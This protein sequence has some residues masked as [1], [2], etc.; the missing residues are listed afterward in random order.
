MIQIQIQKNW[1][2][3]FA[4]ILR[5]TKFKQI[6]FQLSFGENGRCAIGVI[7]EH[8]GCVSGITEDAINLIAQ[9]YGVD[10]RILNHIL[11]LNDSASSFEDI[12]DWLEKR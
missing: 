5:T 10:R 2:H 7:A 3:E 11:Y 6:Y 1:L 8:L 4:Q 12:A 9:T